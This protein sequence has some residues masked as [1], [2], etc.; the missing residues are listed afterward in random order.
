MLLDYLE[1]TAAD[2]QKHAQRDV[3]TDCIFIFRWLDV[4]EDVIAQLPLPEGE[5]PHSTFDAVNAISLHPLQD[6]AS[7]RAT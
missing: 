1:L 5:A 2:V 4:A 7:E 3:I 6:K